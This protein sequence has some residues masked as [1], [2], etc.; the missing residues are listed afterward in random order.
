[1]NTKYIIHNKTHIY[2]PDIYIPSQNK[3]IE[4]KSQYTYKN[5]L[6]KNTIKALYTRLLGY[7]FEFWIYDKYNFKKTIV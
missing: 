5:N 2:Y 1:M 4:I 7:D 6:I 3:V